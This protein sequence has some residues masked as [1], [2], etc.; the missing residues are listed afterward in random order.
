MK[1]SSC[2]EKK[3]YA[4]NNAPR[5]GASTKRNNAAPCRAPA[6]R[7]KGRCR[8]HGGGRG[9]GAQKGNTN[10][11]KQGDTTSQIK[12]F[13]KNVRQIIRESSLIIFDLW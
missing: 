8:I 1:T 4:F 12:E 9:S 11:L 2:T 3:Y 5:C 6:V 10:A 7:G 13:R